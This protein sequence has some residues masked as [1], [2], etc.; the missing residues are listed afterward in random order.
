MVKKPGVV[1]IF[2]IAATLFAGITIRKFVF[3]VSR[4]NGDSMNPT[5]HEGDLVFIEKWDRE[6]KPDDIVVFQP[7]FSK[8]ETFIKRLIA[9][10][11]SEVMIND[12]KV[13]V[14]SKIYTE[15]AQSPPTWGE[16][17]FECRFSS[18][19]QTHASEY[20]VLGDN[21]CMSGDSR[22]FGPVAY[23]NIKGKVVYVLK[24]GRRK[25]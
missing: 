3:S 15:S 12:F 23:D 25:F 24:L 7:P 10:P 20:F 21:R 19:Y 6:F 13:L 11:G 4:V 22:A 17:P 9:S 5:L 1:S 2:L 14:N 18:V 8:T 16:H